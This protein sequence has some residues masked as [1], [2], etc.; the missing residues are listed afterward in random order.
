MQKEQ[1][2]QSSTCQ[3][4]TTNIQTVA[5]RSGLGFC[6]HNKKGRLALLN[7]RKQIRLGLHD[8]GLE[9]NKTQGEKSLP[10]QRD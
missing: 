1:T 9:E 5:V 10:Y 6:L 8:R 2:R 4:T 3:T 7:H